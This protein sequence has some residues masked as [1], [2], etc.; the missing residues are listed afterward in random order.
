MILSLPFY[1]LTMSK[2]QLLLA[3][4]PS[5][6]EFVISRGKGFSST[7]NTFYYTEIIDAYSKNDFYSSSRSGPFDCV[8]EADG[9]N[10]IIWKLSGGRC[11]VSE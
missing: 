9:N 3:S 4:S 5:G 1:Y 10:D 6:I 11:P 7:K 8:I 2:I